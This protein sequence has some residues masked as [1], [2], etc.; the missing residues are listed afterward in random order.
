MYV[1]TVYQYILITK[2]KTMAMMY[3]WNFTEQSHIM[4]CML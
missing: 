4:Y 1:C 2:H 3:F